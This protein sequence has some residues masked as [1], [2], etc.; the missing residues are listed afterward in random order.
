MATHDGI[1]ALLVT[2]KV[3]VAAQTTGGQALAVECRI[4]VKAAGDTVQLVLQL[5]QVTWGAR[6][7]LGDQ[8]GVAARAREGD[9]EEDQEQEGNHDDLGP[10]HLLVGKEKRRV[11]GKNFLSLRTLMELGVDTGMT[12]NLN[13][14]ERRLMDEISFEPPD[15]KS[16]PVR[17]PV[18]FT[19]PR[20]PPPAQTFAGA[21]P[22]MEAFMNPNKSSVPLPPE[23]EMW[24]GGE[25]EM[26]QEP[27]QGGGGG[28][29]GQSGPSEG[30]KTIED[31]KADLL[32]KI[33]RLAKKGL[34]TSSRLTAYS[35]IEEIR[36]E[37]KRLTYAIEV[38]RAI[39]F[40]RRILVACVTGLEFLNKR[41]DPFDLQLDGWS[42]SVMENQ[43]DYDTVFEELYAKYN[44]KVNVAPEVKLIMMV[45]G[46]AMM[47]HL[48]NS[49]FKAA[50]PDMNKVLKQNPD[51]VKNMM[52]AVQRTQSAAPPQQ[53]ETQSGGRREMRGPGLD[54]SA[55]FG[56]MGPPPSMPTR[57]PAPRPQ[58]PDGDDVSD[59]VSVDIGSDT[60]EVNV[61]GGRKRNT[62][63]KEVV[64]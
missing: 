36:T 33:T 4:L 14:D 38:D 9:L 5:E 45:G 1:V 43:D 26:D 47:F 64:L 16:I 20:R 11:K 41:F 17:K 49:M 56:M 42:E 39:R 40:Q 62:K 27:Q 12:L 18:S 28:G 22:G 54:M 23:P 37:Y 63:K 7:R 6:G 60:R 30:Y 29:G 2:D 25:E 48:T 46:S 21:E 44:A 31:E 8:V 51:L 52:D 32:N 55:L 13:D 53:P 19:K 15:K 61:K 57:E 24:D 35:D 59:I 10:L 58:E 34:H 50:M 3:H